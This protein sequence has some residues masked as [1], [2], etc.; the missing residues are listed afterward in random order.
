[1]LFESSVSSMDPFKQQQQKKVKAFIASST[2]KL[3][4]TKIVSLFLTINYKLEGW[5][6]LVS[7]DAT[8][9]CQ[10]LQSD[11]DKMRGMTQSILTKVIHKT[12]N[13][14]NKKEGNLDFLFQLVLLFIS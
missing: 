6:H 7:M 9:R 13:N 5:Q 12:T 1:M 8:H 14:K 2:L 4:K 10:I 11:F 3:K